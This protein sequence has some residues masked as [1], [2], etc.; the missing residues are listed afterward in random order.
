MRNTVV[1][2]DPAGGTQ[3]IIPGLTTDMVNLTVTFLDGVPSAV[4]VSIS[5]YTLNALFQSYRLNGKPAIGFPY[6]GR[7]AGTS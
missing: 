1:Y 6:V 3:P 7:Y 5:N 4:S 2:G